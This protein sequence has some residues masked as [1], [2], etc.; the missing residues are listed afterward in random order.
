MQ[1]LNP[2]EMVGQLGAASE[3]DE[4]GRFERASTPPT[5]HETVYKEL[6]FGRPGQWDSRCLQSDKTYLKY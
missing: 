4:G 6:W 1:E 3:V 5:V 2:G